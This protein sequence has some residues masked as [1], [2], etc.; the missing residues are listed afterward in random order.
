MWKC[1]EPPA[2]QHKVLEV[3]GRRPTTTSKQNCCRQ[4]EARRLPPDDKLQDLYTV[5]EA[6]VDVVV[7]VAQHD[8]VVEARLLVEWCGRYG[9]HDAMRNKTSYLLRSSFQE[10]SR[11]CGWRVLGP[12]ATENS[13][14]WRDG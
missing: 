9:G 11:S 12:E 13:K 5:Q 2:V 1:F 3:T 10:R 6:M 4:I 7:L 8:E 14:R